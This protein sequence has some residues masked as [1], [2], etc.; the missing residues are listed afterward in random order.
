MAV[1][2]TA[3]S[4]TIDT[5]SVFLFKKRGGGGRACVWKAVFQQSNHYHCNHV[6]H[7]WEPWTEVPRW[8][9]PPIQTE[10]AIP[11]PNSQENG[12][13]SVQAHRERVSGIEGNGVLDTFH[14]NGLQQGRLHICNH[15]FFNLILVSNTFSGPNTSK[16]RR[17]LIGRYSMPGLETSD[18]LCWVFTWIWNSVNLH[19]RIKILCGKHRQARF[20]TKRNES[21]TWKSWWSASP[22]RDTACPWGDLEAYWVNQN[23]LVH[24]IP[25]RFKLSFWI[26]YLSNHWLASEAGIFYLETRAVFTLRGKGHTISLCFCMTSFSYMDTNEIW[27]L[28]MISDFFLV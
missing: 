23:Y 12:P 24:S 16:K 6:S 11:Y 1:K 8:V 26:K 27:N 22:G 15:S 3:G 18:S 9:L 28:L 25:L 13:A 21:Y 14:F 20:F 7:K 2:T 4:D 19:F 5:D 10:Q 17:H